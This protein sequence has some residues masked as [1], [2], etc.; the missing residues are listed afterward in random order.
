MHVDGAIIYG[1]IAGEG[2]VD[3]AFA[4]DD[5]AGLGGEEMQDAELRGG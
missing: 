3:D 4:A 1:R 5:A 2:G